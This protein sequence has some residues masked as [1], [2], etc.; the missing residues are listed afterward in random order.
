MKIECYEKLSNNKDIE[1]K[2]NHK[3]ILP[4]LIPFPIES[5]QSNKK[6]KDIH[7]NSYTVPISV[8]IGKMNIV[9]TD[10]ACTPDKANIKNSQSAC[11]NK[12]TNLDSS[13]T[14]NFGYRCWTSKVTYK[15]KFKGVRFAVYGTYDNAHGRFL[16]LLDGIL[17]KTIDEHITPRKEYALLFTSDLL[18]YKEHEI[19]LRPTNDEIYELYK[20]VYWPQINV[21]RMNSS[22]FT[23][24]SGSWH[25]ESDGIGGARRLA[26]SGG[27]A[28]INLN[29]RKFWLYGV[30]ANH[31]GSFTLN[32]NGTDVSISQ[33]SQERVEEALL[34]ESPEFFG[35]DTKL[36]VSIPSGVILLSFIYYE[37]ITYPISIDTRQM[38]LNGDMDCYKNTQTT[39]NKIKNIEK[40][41]KNNCPTNNFDLPSTYNCGYRCVS[42]DGNFRYTFLGEKFAIYGAFDPNYRKFNVSIDNSKNVEVNVQGNRRDRVIIY[43]SDTLEY[44]EH[45]IDI[46]YTGNKY[47]IY[48]L[49]Y[50]PTMTARRLNSTDFIQNGELKTESDTI[51]GIRQYRDPAT[52]NMA[53]LPLK[54]KKFWLYSFK[55]NSQATIDISYN[56]ISKRL[57]L[58]SQTQRE[59]S[60]LIYESEEFDYKNITITLTTNNVLMLCFLYY[61]EQPQPE[62]TPI[63]L[64][65]SL[66]QMTYS[67]TIDCNNKHNSYST[68]LKDANILDSK[69]G[70]ITNNLDTADA[71]QCGFRC[72]SQNAEYT[73][74]FTGVK[75][76][77][78]G[79]YSSS[80]G[81]F[82]IIFDGE[83]IA[84]INTK[85]SRAEYLQ[86][87]ESK[88][89]PYKSHTVKIVAKN[90]ETYELYK[91]A[92]WPTMRAKRYNVTD[93]YNRNNGIETDGIGGIQEYFTDYG[94]FNKT[95]ACSRFWLYGSKHSK[96]TGKTK[97]TYNG[98][99]GEIIHIGEPSGS[100]QKNGVLLLDSKEFA[101]TNIVFVASCNQNAVLYC[102]YYHDEPSPIEYINKTFTNCLP[103]IDIYVPRVTPITKIAGCN[104]IEILEN[105]DYF[106]K[107]EMGPEFYD[108][109]FQYDP[110]QVDPPSPIKIVKNDVDIT[111]RNCTFSNLNERSNNNGVIFYCGSSYKVTVNFVTCQFINC[112]NNKGHSIILIENA[113]SKCD[114]N[115]CSF[116][117]DNSNNS[118]KPIHASCLWA[119]INNCEFTHTG[120]II[121]TLPLNSNEET[122][123]RQFS[124][125]RS[126]FSSSLI[127]YNSDSDGNKYPLCL[128][129]S[130]NNESNI[131]FESNIIRNMI[132]TSDEYQN[133]F[134]KI[135]TNK[136]VSQIDIRNVSFIDNI[137]YSFYGGGSG[138]NLIDISKVSFYDCQFINNQARKNR[139]YRSALMDIFN[140]H[141]YYNGDGGGI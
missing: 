95:F 132:I 7:T 35:L 16:V 135:D 83:N 6:I 110:N 103:Y 70:C 90:S 12:I 113:N 111:I 54:C 26:E 34:F 5:K 141:P 17:I 44:G 10:Y 55:T 51:G 20:I 80:H 21:K 67:G 79:T 94:H 25:Y 75:F 123:K 89:Y 138:I 130:L 127:L 78:Y 109:V 60:V 47:E 19:E 124:I 3:I 88:F 23:T 136:Y 36:T 93:F 91:L 28:S 82:D 98:I 119:N 99:S 32:C 71:F 122:N 33:Y 137:C 13:A 69:L 74:T 72:W 133:C 73:Y 107:L 121:L 126:V 97:Y 59:D 49:A 129:L 48:K 117:F 14:F 50:W 4:K 85:S 22:E 64:S 63:P 53:L 120:R 92:Y 128:D 9:G 62:V 118:P 100:P 41:G 27:S 139:M 131:I 30:T 84:E 65:V 68:A 76:A 77:I 112:G 8:Q 114:F 116:R 96:K 1:I 24:K 42:N 102:F 134:I 86:F 11:G 87:Y 125:T 46:L 101:H 38:Y 56:G 105:V 2:P 39:S 140:D 15:Y 18:E 81:K 57:T 45:T 106:I 61:E 31:L 52:D 43:V 108:N 37:E 40:W 29:C 104:F 58:V 115:D 66:T